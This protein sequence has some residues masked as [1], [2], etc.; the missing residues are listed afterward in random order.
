MQNPQIDSVSSA[1]RPVLCVL[2]VLSAFLVLPACDPGQSMGA[3]GD[4]GE[5]YT[6]PAEDRG[7]RYDAPW[8]YLTVSLTLSPSLV[9]EIRSDPRI[10]YIE[11]MLPGERGVYEGD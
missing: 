6:V 3:G 2:A 1:G 9:P 4:E 11:P 7:T 10:E 8:W 5:E